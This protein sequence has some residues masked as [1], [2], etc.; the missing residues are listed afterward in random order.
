MFEKNHFLY[1]SNDAALRV[2]KRLMRF[3][4]VV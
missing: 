4:G 3:V 1:A 2:N